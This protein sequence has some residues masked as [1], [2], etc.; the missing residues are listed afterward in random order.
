MDML[1]KHYA[2]AYEEAV[3]FMAQ[4]PTDEQARLFQLSEATLLRARELLQRSQ[5]ETLSAIERAELNAFMD[6]VLFVQMR[7]RQAEQHF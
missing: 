5:T 4:V 1:Q 3:A 6:A 7:K 2:R